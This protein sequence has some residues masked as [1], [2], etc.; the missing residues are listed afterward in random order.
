MIQYCII[1]TNSKGDGVFSNQQIEKDTFIGRH[2]TNVPTKLGRKLADGVWET[3]LGRYCNHSNQPN[4]YL[5][6]EGDVYN[7]YASESIEIGD[8]IVV[9]YI[10]V[11]ES[12]GL[13]SNTYIKDEFD[14]G[15]IKNYGK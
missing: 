15:I 13:D 7:I 3:V 10:K 14:N 2:L 1:C 6:F 9:N 11:A 12:L 8:E 4:T 5:K